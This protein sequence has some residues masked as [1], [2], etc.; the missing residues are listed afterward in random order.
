M[1]VAWVATQQNSEF[2]STF[3]DASTQ[4]KRGSAVSSSD[5]NAKL[6]RVEIW[7][8]PRGASLP[9]GISAVEDAPQDVVAQK[10]CPK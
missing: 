5:E 10:G 6:R 3:C 2:K 8:L 9:P 4:E 1:K 7:L